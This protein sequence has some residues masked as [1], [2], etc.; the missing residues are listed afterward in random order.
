MFTA[1]RIYLDP[2]KPKAVAEAAKPLAKP[3]T[4][5]EVMAL[6]QQTAGQHWLDEAHLQRFAV[7]IQRAHGIV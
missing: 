5:D 4:P 2:P 1:S 3:L 6:A 7:A